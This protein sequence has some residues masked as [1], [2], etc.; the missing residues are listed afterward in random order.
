ML[1]SIINSL[2]KYELCLKNKDNNVNS[3]NKSEKLVKKDH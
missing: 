2:K 1:Y 3:L